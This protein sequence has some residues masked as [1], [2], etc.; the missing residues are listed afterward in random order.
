MEALDVKSKVQQ[1]RAKS[2]ETLDSE[3]NIILEQ[4]TGVESYKRFSKARAQTGVDR[5]RKFRGFMPASAQDFEGL[6]YRFL[7]KGEVGDR[8]YEWF[9]ENLL[10][11]LNRAELGMSQDRINLMNDFR[12]LKN[13]LSVPASLSNNAFDGFKNQ[14]VVRMY[15]WM[16]QGMDVPGASKS[17][18]AKVK[19]HMAENPELIT[20]AENI[21]QSLKGNEYTSPGEAWQAGTITTDLIET[22]NGSIRK[23]YLKEFKEKADIIF[24][25]E[26]LNKIEAL[27]GSKFREA[28]E[29]SL[30]RI[31]AGRNRIFSNSRSAAKFA[32]WRSKSDRNNP[33]FAAGG[34][35]DAAIA[36]PTMDRL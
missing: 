28:L 29:N 2:S 1:A 25:P 22:L 27:Y 35:S 11:P 7:G 31:K 33:I 16:S 18:I 24:S 14:D 13:N 17:A 34:A 30:T 36:T 4:S 23:G 26:N 12:T 5:Q 32:L 3:F 15:I 20:F 10:D 9:K 8:Q 19:K 6:L 21:K